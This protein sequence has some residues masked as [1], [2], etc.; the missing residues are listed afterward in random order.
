MG[1]WSQFGDTSGQ[2]EEL[3]EPGGRVEVER[4]EHLLHISRPG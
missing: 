4:L 3:R 2:S 1:A